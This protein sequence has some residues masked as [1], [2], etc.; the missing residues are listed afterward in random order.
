MKN[1]KMIFAGF[2]GQGVLF[3]GKV[4]AYA[5]LFDDN[6]VSWLP[7]YGPEMR[8]GTANCSVCISEN[9]VG[10]PVIASP[11]ILVAM[12]SPSLQKFLP[13]VKAGGMVFTDSTLAKSGAHRPDI[14]L[15]EIPA[16]QLSIS[17]DLEGLTN[18][19]L[20]GK[21]L[22]ESKFASDESISQSL[23][24][25]VPPH[26]AHLLVHNQRAIHLGAAT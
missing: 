3:A 15:F 16:T 25:C 6:Q 11:D 9:T 1:W 5:G 19:I 7:S 8:G 22:R 4:A 23:K 18:M 14:R 10:S 17:E 21:V 13:T 20:L 24:Q 2:G 26:K 12:N